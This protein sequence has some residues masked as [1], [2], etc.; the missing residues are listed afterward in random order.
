MYSRWSITF[1][2]IVLQ[3][4]QSLMEPLFYDMLLINEWMWFCLDSSFQRGH[5][6]SQDHIYCLSLL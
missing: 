6:C 1:S 2:R 4:D 3:L 5:A